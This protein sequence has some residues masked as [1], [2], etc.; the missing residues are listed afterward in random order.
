MIA[1]CL[2]ALRPFLGSLPIFQSLKSG[3]FA[4]AIRA[5]IS[6]WSSSNSKGSAMLH[7]GRDKYQEE[8]TSS[9]RHIISPD[10][11]RPLSGKDTG[12]HVE[13]YAMGPVSR[14]H[15]RLGV[16]NSSIRVERGLDQ[17]VNKV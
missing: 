8:E 2:P 11:S 4:T 17:Y 14:Q 10:G 16:P 15:E 12:P 5:K 13:S 7:S 3:D 9:T 1:A 6:G